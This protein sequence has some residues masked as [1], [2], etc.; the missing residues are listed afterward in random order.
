MER[1]S[2]MNLLCIKYNKMV[3]LGY[4]SSDERLRFESQE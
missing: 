4:G 1:W 2:D 3:D